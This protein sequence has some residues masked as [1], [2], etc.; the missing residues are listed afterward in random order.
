M[1]TYEGKHNNK[2]YFCALAIGQGHTKSTHKS[3]REVG[4]GASVAPLL[5]R[6]C[7]LERTTL[8]EN[9]A[10]DMCNHYYL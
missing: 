8:H 2:N 3:F 1:S 5:P 7:P 10:Y 9:C 6:M 4:T